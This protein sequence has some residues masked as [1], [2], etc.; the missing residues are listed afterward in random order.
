MPW[1]RPRTISERTSS[2]LSCTQLYRS[3]LRPTL[4]RRRAWPPGPRQLAD[5]RQPL[6]PSDSE[7]TLDRAVV[8]RPRLGGRSTT[9]IDKKIASVA[10]NP[11]VELTISFDT[12]EELHVS[13]RP[14][15]RST[16]PTR[17]SKSC[18]AQPSGSTEVARLAACLGSL[19]DRRSAVNGKG[20]V[21]VLRCNGRETRGVNIYMNM[22]TAAPNQEPT[23]DRNRLITRLREHRLKSVVLAA[24][25]L[26]TANLVIGEMTESAARWV[27]PRLRPPPSW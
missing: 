18:T 8:R 12:G 22:K 1:A 23:R 7:G 16:G 3:R 2:D 24:A 27:S 11:G 4:S 14:G 9:L 26:W 6:R 13:L 10:V 19:R 21:P 15:D 20:T 5:H 17:R 25:G